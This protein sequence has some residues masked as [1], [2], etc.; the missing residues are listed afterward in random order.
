MPMP[1]GPPARPGEPG[2]PGIAPGIPEALSALLVRNWWAVALR[3]AVAVLFGIVALLMPVATLLSLALLF[4]A[5]LVIEGVLGIIMAARSAH[6]GRRW[7]ML[8]LEGLFTLAAGIL[9]ALIPG[10]A[11]LSFVL[12]TAAWA[13]ISGGLMLA[14]AFRLHL[15]HGRWWLALGGLLSI[16][17]GVLLVI[18]PVIGAVVLT[19]WLGAY[20]IAFGISLL[21]LGFRLRGR[22]VA[23]AA[24]GA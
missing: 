12:L 11:V 7:G 15:D 18:A 10:G 17:W 19:W 14:A 2:F 13:I 24:Q 16:V 4:A 1:P 22:H 5:Y 20:A 6:D 23:E 3:G 8:L 21:V 9:I